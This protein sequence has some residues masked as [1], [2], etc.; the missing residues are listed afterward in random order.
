[1]LRG[2]CIVNKKA[3]I[4]LLI[5]KYYFTEKCYAL[6]FN[7]ANSVWV[8]FPPKLRHFDFNTSFFLLLGNRFLIRHRFLLYR[9]RISFTIKRR[10][11]LLGNYFKLLSSDTHFHWTT[12]ESYLVLAGSSVFT[13]GKG[14]QAYGLAQGKWNFMILAL[15][16]ML[17]SGP[18]TQWTWFALLCMRFCM[19]LCMR[20][21]LRRQ[22]KPASTFT[23]CAP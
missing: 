8:V 10:F 3:L 18:F 5:I 2:F 21:F 11:S 12:S 7:A 17:A 19:H 20:L 4:F 14:T 22:W 16:P 6:H 23:F 9:S 13:Q 1:M 15:S